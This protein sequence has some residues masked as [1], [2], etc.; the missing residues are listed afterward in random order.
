MQTL[1]L[2]ADFCKQRHIYNKMLSHSRT[3]THTS[4]FTWC[5]ADRGGIIVAHI[6]E[7]NERPMKKTNLFSG[8]RKSL[9]LGALNEM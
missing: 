9:N 4:T 7:L 3:H 8:Y 5:D 1:K 2:R 6:Y